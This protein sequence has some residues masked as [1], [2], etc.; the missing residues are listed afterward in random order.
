MNKFFP[1]FAPGCISIPVKNLEK[2]Y[3]N[4]KKKYKFNAP[5]QFSP[6]GYAKVT[7]FRV[8]LVLLMFF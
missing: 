6:D 5:P 1:I 8:R 7:F 3:N 4:L 2:T